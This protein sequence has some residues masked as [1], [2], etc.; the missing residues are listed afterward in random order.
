MGVMRSERQADHS[1]P[2]SAEVKNDGALP[3]LPLR[4]DE[5]MLN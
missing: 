2:S 3:P 4:K 1:S 5:V